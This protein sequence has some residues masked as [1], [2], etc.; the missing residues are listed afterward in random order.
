[1]KNISPFILQKQSSLKKNGQISQSASL[2]DE[3]NDLTRVSLIWVYRDKNC[4]QACPKFHSQWAKIGG[5][6]I[7]KAS[8]YRGEQISGFN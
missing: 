5:D 2:V 8:G 6:F 7:G 3:D 1:M 4:Y